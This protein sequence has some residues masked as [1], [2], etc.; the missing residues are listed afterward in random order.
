MENNINFFRNTLLDVMN[1]E[2]FQLTI[3]KIFSSSVRNNPKQII[4]YQGRENVTYEEFMKRVYAIARGLV[5]LGVKKGDRVAVL[6][7]DSMRYLEAYYAIPLAGGVLHT[8]NIRY[9][10]DLIFYTMQHADDRFVIIRDEFVP[11][12]EKSIALFDFVKAWIVSSD[13]PDGEPSLPGSYR[14]HSLSEGSEDVELPELNEDDLATVFYTSGTTG[15]PKGVSFTHRQIL[16]HT[17]TMGI[18]LS[19]EPINLK[20]TDVVMPLVPMFHVH[21]WGIPFLAILKGM[22]YVLPGRYDFDEIPKI[23]QQ[24][25]VSISLMVP[26]ILYMLMN[27]QN[28]NLLPSLKLRVTVG[29]GALPKGLAEKA[30][31]LGLTV[32]AGYGMSETAPI[33][34]LATYN[35][36]VFSLTDEQRADFEIKTGIPIPLVDL[37]VVDSDGKELPWDS[38]SIGEIVVRGP[39]LTNSYIKDEANTKKLWKDGWMHTGDLAVVDE[40]GYISIVDREKDAVKSGGEFIPTVIL[41]DMIST[42]P[43]IGEVAVVGRKDEKWGERPVAFISG[44]KDMDPEKLSKHLESFVIA[45]RIAKFWIPDEYIPIDAFE[46]TSTGK[47]DKKVLREKLTRS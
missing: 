32:N 45:G 4:S 17:L 41:E 20:S 36:H 23:M 14:Y 44:L 37:R 35:K 21:S 28:R 11:I 39:W 18:A 7:W 3:D 16:L 25:K 8:V 47:I 6:D 43:G 40:H 38:K 30:K 33:L 2:K 46:K 22:K 42:Y 13:K 26:S 31:Q 15:L 1:G 10:P 19:D 24:E 12:I 5:K 27:G 29:G 34:S 9:P